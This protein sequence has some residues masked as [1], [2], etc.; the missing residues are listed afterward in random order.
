MEFNQIL[1][2]SMEVIL[3]Y[4]MNEHIVSQIMTSIQLNINTI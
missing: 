1:Y 3:I 2:D 4:F